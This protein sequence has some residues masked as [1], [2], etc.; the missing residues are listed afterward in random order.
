MGII[1]PCDSERVAGAN[2]F[3]TVFVGGRVLTS[4]KELDAK[5]IR[6]MDVT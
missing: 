2:C 5:G 6:L 1:R 4:Y 3:I